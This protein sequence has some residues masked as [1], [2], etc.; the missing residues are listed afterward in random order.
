MRFKKRSVG[1]KCRTCGESPISVYMTSC[2]EGECM[3]MTFSGLK[4]DCAQYF[5][6]KRV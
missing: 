1:R 3:L 6:A 5:G 2:I 4:T